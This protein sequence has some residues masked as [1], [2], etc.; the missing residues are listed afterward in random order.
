MKTNII[1]EPVKSVEPEM[2]MPTGLLTNGVEN[3]MAIEPS[4]PSLTWEM[5]S[6]KRGDFQSAYQVVIASCATNITTNIGDI[7][8]SGKVVS[9][10]SA[11]V[12][13]GIQTLDS[14]KRYFWKVK[15]WNR[16]DQ[17][18]PYSEV[19]IFDTGLSKSD[20]KAKY[21]WDGVSS[22]NHFV[23][24]RKQFHVRK[25]IKFA[26]VFV[27]AHND[28]QLFFNGQ[29]LGKG[30]ARS[31]PYKAGN[32][33]AYDITERLSQGDNV[34]AAISHWHGVWNDSGVN[35]VPAFLLEARIEY[36]DGQSERIV[37]DESWKT[38][39]DTPFIESNPVYFGADG[40]IKNRAAIIYDG[41]KELESWQRI[42]FDD[43]SW[44]NVS[45]IEHLDYNLFA[46]LVA[47]DAEQEEIT[48]I[49][50]T[51]E[52]SEWWVEFDRCI[53]GWPKLTM[54]DNKKGSKITINYYQLSGENG[55]AGWDQY[56][57]KGGKET[58]KT[59]IG[60][61]TS[62]KT[63][64]ISGYEGTLTSN[65]VKG[66]WSY[67]SAIVEGAFTCSNPL[68]NDIFTMCERSA[69]QNVQQG[70][71]SVDANREQSPWTADSWNI[72]LG[73]LYNHKNTMILDKVIKDYIGEQ[74][75]CGDF[76]A[77]SPAG[78][79]RIPEWAM[80]IPMILW[81][82]YLFSGQEELL[83]STFGSLKKFL[84]WIGSFLDPTLDLIDPP[85]G[86]WID[87]NRFSDYA[88][89]SL[90]SAG[91]NVATNSQY[92]ENLRVA[93]E[94]ST[95]LG[96]EIDAINYGRQAEA[97]KTGI[98]KNLLIEGTQYLSKMG[99]LQTISLGSC[100]PLRFDIVPNIDKEAVKHWIM[101][102]G[103][104]DFGGYGGDAFYNGLYTA[105]GMGSY[106][107]QDLN[108]YRKMLDSNNTNW[109]QWEKGEYNHAWT[110]Y[111]AYLFHKY[112]AGIQPTSGGFA[113]F[114]IKPEIEGLDFAES[115]VPTVKGKISS[116]WEK[117]TDT[118]MTLS[119]TIPP[120]TLAT[121]YLPKNQLSNI[122]IK[123]SG[124]TIWKEGLEDGQVVT[125]THLVN[126]SG[127]EDNFIRFSVG[128]GSYS[129]EVI[130][131]QS[132]LS[133]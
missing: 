4:V 80:Y 1:I 109:E 82:Q 46:Q 62:F 17:E 131:G 39:G 54:T 129:F 127:D 43:A 99:E 73:L 87:S 66:I 14:G 132:D 20:W 2:L 13:P 23:Y 15:I 7:W 56:I 11:G 133:S 101:N 96:Y 74:L 90:L 22:E 55:E 19:A 38:L 26:K 106:I 100:W 27:T 111:P 117:V 34:F 70:I 102:F 48:P 121:V 41:R 44:K 25:K 61:H 18:G 16:E 51:Q 5:N 118:H 29:E 88:G 21:I 112:I 58:W 32:Y 79:Y 53:N 33:N 12:N 49:S 77:C 122:I 30:P 45:I 97:V 42:D 40:G 10:K 130:G 47:Q 69:R 123:E 115:S 124:K 105:G 76:Y 35:A 125:T 52:G 120:N 63:L 24:F 110:C 37:T 126:F 104:S 78:I 94:I 59:N 103:G 28:Y 95:V 36:E 71:I 8:D 98:N 9:S 108:R 114:N 91:Y 64:K 119:C 50:I 81:Q 31:N 93:S 60:R 116:R 68:L 84:N 113:T 6:L 57:C 65:E 89:G 67:T 72:G 83:R 92:Y 85:A 75:E 86:S 128:A 3:P 107:I